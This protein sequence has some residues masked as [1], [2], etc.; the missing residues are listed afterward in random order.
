MTVKAEA[1]SPIASHPTRLEND[2]FPRFD[3]VVLMDKHPEQQNDN[4]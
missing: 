2:K 1:R 3:L 4:E